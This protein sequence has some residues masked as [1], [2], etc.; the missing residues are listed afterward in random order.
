M[1]RSSRLQAWH[2]QRQSWDIRWLLLDRCRARWLRRPPPSSVST[3]VS[4][5]PTAPQPTPRRPPLSRTNLHAHL[6]RCRNQIL[7]LLLLCSAP[8]VVAEPCRLDCAAACCGIVTNWCRCPA[9]VS[10]ACACAQLRIYGI[11]V[12]LR[13]WVCSWS[14]PPTPLLLITTSHSSARL[15]GRAIS[16]RAATRPVAGRATA[17]AT[18][19]TASSSTAGAVWL[20]MTACSG[21]NDCIRLHMHGHLRAFWQDRHD[22]QYAA[23]R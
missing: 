12:G 22:R 23:W 4:V 10:V 6:V 14:T 2:C 9:R 11:C 8:G 20:R 18:R 21:S 16:R 1:P 17:A 19:A 15:L 13:L 5:K 3:P 7:D